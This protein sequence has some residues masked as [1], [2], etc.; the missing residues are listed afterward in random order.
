[1][2]FYAACLDRSDYAATVGRALRQALAPV[3]AL[4]DI[5]A[6]SGLLGRAMLQ[7]GSRWPAVEPSAHMRG[8]LEHGAGVV[9][10]R[11]ID[12]AWENLPPLARHD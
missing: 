1:A 8:R 2:A 12:A 5:G 6:G 3:T 9:R 4:L 11:V 7:P 10:P